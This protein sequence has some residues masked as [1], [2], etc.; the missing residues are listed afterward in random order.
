MIARLGLDFGNVIKAHGA[1]V[2]GVKMSILSLRAEFF[3]DEVYLVSRVE[4]DEGARK[5]DAFLQENGFY[6]LINPANVHYC[7]KRHE[8][9]PITRFL[10]ISHFVD[11]RTEVLSY[12]DTVP[13]RYAFNPEPEQLNAFPPN[14][15]YLVHTWE[16]VLL[17]IQKHSGVWLRDV[18]EIRQQERNTLAERLEREAAILQA[19]AIYET[20]AGS[21][22]CEMQAADYQKMA[23]ELRSSL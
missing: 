8:K 9:A 21:M 18:R 11:D 13:Y 7:Y 20:L 4:T 6:D 12:M 1:L 5:T 2:P 22:R 16:D 3:G 14:G 17:H 23:K 10:G 19:T 15:M